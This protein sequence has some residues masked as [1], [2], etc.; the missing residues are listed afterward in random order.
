MAA[1]MPFDISCTKAKGRAETL[2]DVAQEGHQ[3]LGLL[4]GQFNVAQ[5]NFHDRVDAG[6]EQRALLFVSGIQVED[7]A[8]L[9]GDGLAEPTGRA[10]VGQGQKHNKSTPQIGDGGGA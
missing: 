8:T 3:A 9:K 6:H 4:A 7:V 10:A 2:L 5:D 1:R